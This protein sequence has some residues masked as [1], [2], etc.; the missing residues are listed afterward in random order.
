MHQSRRQECGAGY[1]TCNVKTSWL[2]SRMKDTLP[3]SPSQ[4]ISPGPRSGRCCTS[5]E[6]VL[7]HYKSEAL[8]FN[9]EPY[10]LH[11]AL[12]T[13]VEFCSGWFANWFMWV[14]LS[15]PVING[16]NGDEDRK[17]C[18]VFAISQRLYLLHWI[19]Q[20]PHDNP[21][22][23]FLFFLLDIFFIYIFNV[24]PFPSFLSE[25]PLSPPTIAPQPTH[26]CLLA[27]A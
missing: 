9:K 12:C 24:I 10:F 13:E 23:F 5:S 15:P 17:V 25:N 3:A 11:L 26:S 4:F 16:G 20:F 7:S 8:Q 21:F 6:P 22:F 2:G 14:G 1:P 19:I 18:C 27:L